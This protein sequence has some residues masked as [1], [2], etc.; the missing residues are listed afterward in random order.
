MKLAVVTCTYNRPQLLPRV[1]HCFDNQDFGNRW[2]LVYDDGGQYASRGSIRRELISSPIRETSLGA[3]RNTSILLATVAFSLGPDDG[4]LCCD[5][6]DLFMAWHLSSAA[7]ALDKAEWS[8]PS[9]VLV[10]T[11]NEGIF[12]QTQTGHRDDPTRE[13]MYHPAWA[14]RLSA[15]HRV[16][17]YPEDQSGMEDKG[18]MLKMEAA[19]AIQAD[20]IELGFRPSYVHHYT[21]G[22][23]ISSFLGP[24]DPLG[25]TAWEKLGKILPP[26]KLDPW[27]PTF[28]LCN[29]TIL[30][31]VLPRGF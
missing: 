23:S 2:M 31:G 8:R 26:A 24:K 10:P 29:P 6:D 16:G 14:F 15:F 5:D 4:I 13:R 11:A 3:K 9:V 18:F 19:G 17:G 28:D 25:K 27:E 20:P 22:Q 30:P 21:S 1:I 7:A 12:A